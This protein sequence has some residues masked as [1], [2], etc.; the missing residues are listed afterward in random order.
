MPPA[1]GPKSRPIPLQDCA[2]LIRVAAYCERAEDGGVGIGNRLEKSKAGGDDADPEK[3]SP[4]GG[5]MGGR[6]EPEAAHRHHQQTG[7]DAALVSQLR[8]EPARRERH[9]EVAQIMRELHPGRLRQVQV[10]LLL[11]M[12]VHHVDHAVAKTPESEEKNQEDKNKSTFLPSSKTNMLRLGA[13][14]G[15]SGPG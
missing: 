15:S 14:F 4:E 5:D 8:G 6:D 10:Q 9:Q 12:L 7:D 13:S 1:T 11:K 2:R 3:K